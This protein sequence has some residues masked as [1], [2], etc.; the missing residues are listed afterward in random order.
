MKKAIILAGGKGTRLMPL[1]E[2]TP[3]PL[4]E[5]VDKTLCERIICQLAD[6]GIKEILI[7]VG[8]LADKIKNHIGSIYADTQIKYLEET[9]P[10]GTAGGLKHA[11]EILKLSEN[12]NFLVISGDCICDFDFR[13]IEE[14]HKNSN[15]KVTIVT[16][17]SDFPLE[18]GIVVCESGGTVKGFNE[19]PSWSQVS[20]NRVNTGIYIVNSSV[21]ELIPDGMYDFSKDLFPK[22]LKESYKINAFDAQGYWCDIGSV[23]SYYKCVIDALE[24][25]IKNFSPRDSADYNILRKSG[26]IIHEPCYIHKSAVIERNAVIGPKTS[27]SKDCIIKSGAEI[28]A[29]VIHSGVQVSEQ[30]RLEGAI[31]CKNVSIGEKSIICGGAVV[32]DGVCL[33]EKSYISE[34][35][36]VTKSKVAKSENITHTNTSCVVN[37]D[38]GF[39]LGKTNDMSFEKCVKFG[40]A[41]SE[42]AGK[43]SKTG[44]M[45]EKNMYS[46]QFAS[47]V[48]FGLEKKGMQIYDFGEGFQ[49]LANCVSILFDTE[50]FLYIY[51]DDNNVYC[52]ITEKNA[53]TAS[54][55]FERKLELAYKTCDITGYSGLPHYSHIVKSPSVYYYSALCDNARVYSKKNCFEGMKVA[56]ESDADTE[57]FDI[58]KKVYVDLGGTVITPKEAYE[59]SSLIVEYS[60]TDGI[61]FKQSSHVL[62]KYHAVAAILQAET[63]R[64]MSQFAI[65]YLSPKKYSEIA[66]ASSTFFRY[67][68]HSCKSIDIP[69][70]T[71][72]EC[73]WA[74][75][76]IIMCA[77]FLSLVQA[78]KEN[79]SEL[80]LSMPIFSYIEKS[81]VL[82]DSNKT[83][84][85]KQIAGIPEYVVQDSYEGIE[86]S[87]PNGTITVVPGKSN[88]FKIYSE[89]INSEIAS[90]LCKQTENMLK[91]YNE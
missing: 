72:K 76:D 91:Q 75:D 68:Y 35:T 90:E 39:L 11:K 6:A 26:V 32:G 20:G 62:D 52:S 53:M 9:V 66:G 18:Y 33:N 17:E 40:I 63:E 5:F 58:M 43:Y 77:R 51:T 48:L 69:S 4:T 65:P 61:T 38:K 86:I 19:K 25:R 29:S 22:M 84:M 89:A 47:A 7:T 12:E 10:L 78:K 82:N 85:I 16:S 31:I 23:E 27:I 87:Y 88:I 44:I 57:E 28:A 83:R 14:N 67:P 37:D 54:H 41:L 15:A 21:V 45:Y 3:K 80:V 71:A 79:L 8:Y 49:K 42:T 81:F 24:G 64:G 74:K 59:S 36:S 2:E 1:T 30:C 60:K 46:K 73:L 50:C 55:E 70:E 56:F 13:E 34:N